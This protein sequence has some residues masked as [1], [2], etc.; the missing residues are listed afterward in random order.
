MSVAQEAR[1]SD[2]TR[3]WLLAED[4]ATDDAAPESEERRPNKGPAL[5]PA[6]FFVFNMML[7][8][9]TCLLSLVLLLITGRIVPG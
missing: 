1:M 2:D 3:S 9:V 5:S 4:E 8:F 7:F 6:A